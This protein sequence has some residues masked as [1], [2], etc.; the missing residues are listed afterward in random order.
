MQGWARS[1]LES[2]P[3]LTCLITPAWRIGSASPSWFHVATQFG[4]APAPGDDIRTLR[5]PACHDGGVVHRAVS[6]VLDGRRPET[7]IE[8]DVLDAHGRLRSFSAIVARV[9][10]PADAGPAFGAG[11]V[12]VEITE[13]RALERRLARARTP[14]CG[15]VT[16]GAG[17]LRSDDLLG[18]LARDELLLAYQPAMTPDGS[19]AVLVEALLRWR[20]PEFG[21]LTPSVFLAADDPV[22]PDVTAWVIEQ[23]AAQ[24]R[25][26]PSVTVTVNLSRSELIDGSAL[27]AFRQTRAAGSGGDQLMVEVRSDALS[28]DTALVSARIQELAGLG[29]R[30]ITDGVGEGPASPV[31]LRLP[32]VHMIKV[33]RDVTGRVLSDRGAARAL[34]TL[35]CVGRA[36]EVPVI[37]VGVESLALRDAA[38]L[39]GATALQGFAIAPPMHAEEIPALLHLGSR[40]G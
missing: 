20:H 14:T 31:Y 21:L 4:E 10:L 7:T 22:P 37:A 36:L 33:G 1:P 24:A 30:V 25:E 28:A 27:T 6:E 8:Y 12:L 40:S 19:T 18:A 13:R 35:V 2:T 29:I 3:T 16:A 11:V 9:P 38:R 34:A 5:F 23:A 32:E 39:L 26:W 17:T 15:D